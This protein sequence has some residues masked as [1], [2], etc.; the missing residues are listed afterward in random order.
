MPT[1]NIV[2]AAITSGATAD[3]TANVYRGLS[4]TGPW[5]RIGTMDLI[6]GPTDPSPPEGYFYDN[7]APFGVQVWYRVR[8]VNATTGVEA[9]STVLG[10]Y[11]LADPGTVVI[12]DP[13]RPWADLEF[14]FC[15][16]PSGLLS[17]ACTPTGPE[18]LWARFG[19][20]LRASDAGLF[21]VLDAERPADVYA[22]RKDHSGTGSFLTK[23][24]E[25][26]DAVDDLFTAG[27][28]LYLRAPAV[29]GRTD[30]AFQPG[31]LAEVFLTDRIDQRFPVRAWSFPYVVIDTPLGRQQGTACANWCAVKA[32]YPTFADLTA[33]GHTWGAIATGETVCPGTTGDGYGFGP[34]GDGPYGDGG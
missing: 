6:N 4:A 10:P 3:Y 9:N 34:Y 2:H 7:T 26:V 24:L 18:L 17:A 29:Y 32:T 30:F 20:R 22:R 31:D 33:T 13:L 16:S 15:D 23:S 11:T 14:A 8:Q 21:P 12:S 5:T 19:D 27:G 25:A 1:Y 28:P